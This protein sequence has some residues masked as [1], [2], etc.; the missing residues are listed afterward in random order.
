MRNEIAAIK[1]LSQSGM[2]AQENLKLALEA[3]VNEAKPNGKE[4]VSNALMKCRKA[5]LT[6]KDV[7]R[8]TLAVARQEPRPLSS[9]HPREKRNV[10]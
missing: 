6:S 7:L 8:C 4:S 10:S 5:K 9:I 1:R 3:V 2:M